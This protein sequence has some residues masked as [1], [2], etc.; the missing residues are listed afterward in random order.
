M[1]IL[2]VDNMQIRQYGNFKMGPGQKLVPGAFRNNHRVAEFSDR[3]IARFLTPIG[4]RKIGGYL[5]NKKLIRTAKNFKPDVLFISHCD[6]IRNWALAEIRAALPN[7]R[8]AHFNVDAL[9]IQWHVQQI[10]ERMYSTDAIF[11]TTGGPTLKQ[12]CTGKNIVAYMPN[13]TDL[14]M[15]SENNATKTNLTHDLLFC[16]RELP[17]DNRNTLLLDLQQRLMD[18]LRFHVCGMF[19]QPPVWGAAYEATLAASKMALNLNRIEGWPLYSSDRIAHLMGNGILTF[20]NDQGQLQR[21]FS[22]QEAVFFKN[23]DDLSEKIL[24]FHTHADKCRAVANAGRDCYHRLFNSERVLKFMLET[25]LQT[26][27]SENYEWADEVYQ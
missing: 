5:A 14:S 18:K 27:Y 20:L 16:G 17:D 10:Q 3:D 22:E 8:M 23:N 21:F 1:R 7:I 24:Y 13:P 12:F 6:Y 26:P 15:E 19:G 2:F 9:W 11:V 25:L 4:I